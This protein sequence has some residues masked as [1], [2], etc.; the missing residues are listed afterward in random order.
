M[1]KQIDKDQRSQV[2]KSLTKNGKDRQITRNIEKLMSDE[3]TLEI[4]NALFAS[5]D[6]NKKDN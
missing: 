4:M 2:I 5:L 3:E 6:S 1:K